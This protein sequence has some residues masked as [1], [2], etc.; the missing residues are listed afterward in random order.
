MKLRLSWATFSSVFTRLLVLLSWAAISLSTGTVWS[1]PSKPG[2]WTIPASREVWYGSLDTA[3]RL[4]GIREATGRNDGPEILAM[5]RAARAPARSPYCI[6][7]HVWS[8]D[9][10]ARARDE[11]LPILRS[12]LASAVFHDARRRG[13]RTEYRAQVG[14]IMF[15]RLRQTIFG[16]AERI[17]AIGKAGWVTTIAGNVKCG[18]KT[19]TERD[20]NGICVKRRNIVHPMG[21][22]FVL[23]LIGRS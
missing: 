19:G 9:V 15:W 11:P 17:I 3:K 7:L 20:G 5:Q 4:I 22:L 6:S 13:V 16:H 2:R 10:T 18:T 21:A 23:G 14:D 8:F 12:A 1:Q